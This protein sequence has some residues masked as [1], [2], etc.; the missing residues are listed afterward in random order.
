MLTIKSKGYG[1][2]DLQNNGKTV[3]GWQIEKRTE[4][5]KSI[6]Y[7]YYACISTKTNAERKTKKMY[8]KNNAFNFIISKYEEYLEIINNRTNKSFGIH[9]IF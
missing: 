8:D 4:N 2:W 7:C 5:K 3:F 9:G 6:Y 1:V